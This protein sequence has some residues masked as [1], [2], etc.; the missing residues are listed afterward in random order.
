MALVD[1]HH[2]VGL[3]QRDT[4]GAVRLEQPPEAASYHLLTCEA[5]IGG[6]DLPSA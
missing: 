6:R 1:G 2:V 4:D 3:G 5:R